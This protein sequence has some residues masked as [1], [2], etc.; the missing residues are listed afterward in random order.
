MR[1]S[2]FTGQDYSFSSREVYAGSPILIEAIIDRQVAEVQ[3]VK[4]L[5]RKPGR[6]P[7]SKT[8]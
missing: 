2:L 1:D 4:I 8:I 6:M 7:S 5:F 3:D